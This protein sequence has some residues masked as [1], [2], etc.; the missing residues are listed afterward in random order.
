MS[1]C[2][3]F[4]KNAGEACL[5]T[6]EKPKYYLFPRGGKG[7]KNQ[8]KKFG[9]RLSYAKPVSSSG[10]QG[11][12]NKKGGGGE[13]SKSPSCDDKKVEEFEISKAK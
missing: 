7:P 3:A 6:E 12:E 13:F 4:V 5:L 11:Y 9:P 2:P 10:G 8:V 1:T